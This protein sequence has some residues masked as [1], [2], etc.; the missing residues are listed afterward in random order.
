MKRSVAIELSNPFPGLRPFREDEEH[1]FFGRES[2]V[3]SM[4]DKLANTRFLAVVGTSGSGKSSLVNCGLRPALH[5]GLMVRAG[6]SWRIAQFR[7][8]SNPLRAMALALAKNGALLGGFDPEG[9]ALEDMVVAAL[10]MSK[11][12]LADVYEQAQL[13]KSV[14]LLV[15]VDQFEELFRY[16]MLEA[17]GADGMDRT[18]EATAF[19]NLLLEPKTQAN[20]PIYVVLTM[21]SDFLGDCAEFPR[22]PEAINEGQY[23]VPRMTREE[24]RAAITGPAGVGGGDVSPV[25]L[26]RLV[27]DVGDNPDQ[28]SILQHALNRTWARWQH[29]G[30]GEGPL[31]L[32][33]YE[34]IG[35]MAHA[36]DQHAEKAYR[37]LGSERQERICE[38]IFKALTDKGT[39]ARGIR[40]PTKLATLCAVADASRTEVTSVID[41]FRKPSRS[42]LMPP[43]PE[44]LEP[45]TIIDISHESLMRVWERLKAWADDEAQSAQLYRRLSETAAL[46]PAG[47]AS[48][49][50]GPDLELAI[51]WRKK[52]NPTEVWAGLQR[53]S[54]GQAMAFL[55]ESEAQRDKEAREKEEREARELEQAQ[56]LALA[57][58]QARGARRL[59]RLFTAAVALAVLA[60]LAAVYAWQQ[61]TLAKGR[62]SIAREQES[63]A[64]EQ[65]SIANSATDKARNAMVDAVEQRKLAEEATKKAERLEREAKDESKK[66]KE[67]KNKA[68]SLRLAEGAT[69]ST[70]AG[71]MSIDPERGVLLA[72]EAV[73]ATYASDKT[74]TPEAADALRQALQAFR[75]E[76]TLS[77]RGAAQGVAFSSDGKL[78]AIVTNYAGKAGKAVREAMLWDAESGKLLA[79]LLHPGGVTSCVFS[80]G[81]RN[82]ATLGLEVD[83]TRTGKAQ[84][85]TVRLWDLAAATPIEVVGQLQHQGGVRALAFSP[86]DGKYLA[87]ASED[88]Y[89]RLWDV[90]SGSLVEEMQHDG[91]VATV[92]FTSDAHYLVT[93]S[94]KVVRVS[95]IGGESKSGKSKIPDMLHPGRVTALAIGANGRIATISQ[96]AGGISA[97][98]LWDGLAGKKICVLDTHEETSAISF[99]LDGIRLAT[100]ASNGGAR[101][102]D[103]MSCQL[104]PG[105]SGDVKLLTFG[106]AGQVATAGS[107]NSARVWNASTGGEL[108]RLFG[109]KGNITSI[110]FSPDGKRLATAST[111]G[112]VRTW[113]TLPRIALMDRMGHRDVIYRVSFSADGK[114]VATA[115]WDTTAK[116]WDAATGKEL[117]TLSGHTKEVLGVAFS[118]NGRRIATCSADNTAKVWDASSGKVLFT[119]V[120]HGGQVR[121]ITFSPDGKLLATASWDKTAKIW[122]AS[123]GKELMILKGHT[124][125]VEDVAFSPDGK[126][127]ATAS[128]D[129]T[130]KVWEATT[131]KLRNTLSRHH[132]WVVGV[133]FSPD[134]KRLV[135]A[136]ADRTARVWEIPSGTEIA[137]LFGHSGAVRSAVFS[138]DGK[139][140][141]TASEDNTTKVWAADSGKAFMTLLGHADKV[142]AVTFSPDGSRLVT[143]GSDR[144]ILTYAWGVEELVRL[145]KTRVTRQLTSGE[146]TEYNVASAQCQKVLAADS[147]IAEG[148]NQARDIQW[149]A[150][151]A[152]FQRAKDLN[153][154]LKLDPEK[155]AK[156]LAIDGLVA[157]GDDLVKNDDIDRAVATVRMA[158]ELDPSF[159][160]NRQA[161]RDW[162]Q[163]GESLARS[164]DVDGAIAIFRRTQEL[165]PS[166]PKNPEQEAYEQAAEGLLDRAKQLV[167]QDKVGEAIPA[168]LE[169]VIA[170]G[171]AQGLDPDGSIRAEAWND[172]C[173][174]SVRRRHAAEVMEVCERA[175]RLAEQ[176]KPGS[177]NSR[178][179][180]GVARAL[181]GDTNGAIEDFQFYIDHTTD[182]EKKLQ[183]QEWV[184]ALRAGKKPD[185]VLKSLLTQ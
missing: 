160:G 48:L 60:V 101:M 173:W 154:D 185:E 111:D 74:T 135:T 94:D 131:G 78:C 155:E 87:T 67:R 122:D 103:A 176:L 59:S 4:V 93:S 90:H 150:A 5:R 69:V 102:W 51:E 21:R 152:T 167:R 180:R 169:A 49:Y 109:H 63:I 172:L 177:W 31:D 121:A 27:N 107:D 153:P 108:F 89:A 105:Y 65:E 15:I 170:Y 79:P 56:A 88:G 29:E 52:E 84:D 86:T 144:R 37:E 99:S 119:L 138:P 80:L 118:P 46:N 3:D 140:L 134:G 139:Y 83:S 40:R 92:A 116:V 35:T 91:A 9:L 50:S 44:T 23:L 10:R 57:E 14:N 53:G 183:R 127:L 64:R 43:L 163:K 30:F 133:A 145:A 68:D 156:R 115:S 70:G 73:Q 22:L 97:V 179:S 171:R 181:T 162:A 178:D 125:H 157:K 166:W 18:E 182:G 47:R 6:T 114:T 159:K 112:T 81:K 45:E 168:Y 19:V 16:R 98:T 104:S 33:H 34:A 24:R 82:V 106:A 54:F 100:V 96:P 165:D 147:L 151:A 141:A 161:A 61:R 38:K 95:D 77:L 13:D 142:Y 8:G 85:T 11:L 149:K 120:G 130:A 110:A 26:T 184:N 55:A 129:M 146:C 148:R 113:S 132:Y 143:A 124:D 72:T 36:L 25:L 76:Q 137:V 28:L 136:S 128:S 39:D 126:W 75:I 20:L 2:Q 12:G 158:K 117:L 71:G 62:E 41:I 58:E 175:V 17:S 42:F 32:P 123:I 7:P 1:L 66:D 164:G 174:E